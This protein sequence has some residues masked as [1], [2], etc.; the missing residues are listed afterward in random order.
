VLG[1]TKGEI[2]H[3]YLSAEKARKTLGWKPQ[4]SLEAGLRETI[5]WYEEFFRDD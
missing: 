2:N 3:Q 4:Y 1:E 5:A